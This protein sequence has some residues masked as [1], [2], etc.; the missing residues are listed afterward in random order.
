MMATQ[1]YV[2]STS[3]EQVVE[4]MFKFRQ[5]TRID[6][7]LLMSALLSKEALEQSDRYLI[8]QVTDAIKNGMLRVVD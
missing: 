5:I 3:V 6:Q 4:R 7:Q 1:V 8:K 2:P